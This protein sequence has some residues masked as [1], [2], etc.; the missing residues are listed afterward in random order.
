MLISDKSWTGGPGSI[1]AGLVCFTQ[2]NRI[3]QNVIREVL[4]AF[5]VS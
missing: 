4:E 5:L 1:Q 3:A 2:N